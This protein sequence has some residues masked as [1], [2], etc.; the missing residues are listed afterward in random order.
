[1]VGL[2]VAGCQ[3]A[4]SLCDGWRPIPVRPVTAAYLVAND[5]PA[6]EGI[7]GHNDFGEM[8]CGWK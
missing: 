2:S 1:M 5:R 3:T 7:A 4:G 6:A 8:K